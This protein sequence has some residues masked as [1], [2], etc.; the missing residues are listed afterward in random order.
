MTTIEILL[1]LAGIALCVIS[2]LIPDKQQEVGTVDEKQ[3]QETT[4]ALV[5]EELSGAKAKMEE[6]LE[7]TIAYG[8]E[9]TERSLE[10]VSNEKINAVS[11]FAQTVI[12]DINKNHKE[13]MFLYD[14]LNSKHENL[15]ET[16]VEVNQT[17]KEAEKTVQVLEDTAKKV[18]NSLQTKEQQKEK[19]ETREGTEDFKPLEVIDFMGMPEVKE[20][21][22]SSPKKKKEKEQTKAQ[23]EKTA[24]VEIEFEGNGDKNNNDKILELHKM[25]KS[26]MAIAKELGLGVGEV[27]LVI[28]LFKGM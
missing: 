1:C 6:M 9:K 18:E 24:K 4:K 28:D 11:E 2:F 26:N 15:K 8:M 16:V 10:K 19:K 17:A 3:A 27:K 14:M 12:E 20:T 23:E 5:E 25:G 22:K 21:K 13:V 7:E